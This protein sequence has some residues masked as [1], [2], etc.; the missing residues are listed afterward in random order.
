MQTNL[1]FTL[2]LLY[3]VGLGTM[4]KSYEFENVLVLLGYCVINLWFKLRLRILFKSYKK[5]LM[6]L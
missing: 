2:V 1:F 3:F 5:A 6:L 4:C